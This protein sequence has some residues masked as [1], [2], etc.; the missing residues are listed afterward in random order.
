[1]KYL[2][3]A[4]LSIIAVLITGTAAAQRITWTPVTDGTMDWMPKKQAPT[5]YQ[6]I[7]PGVYGSDGSRAYVPSTV[8]PENGTVMQPNGNRGVFSG[9]SYME[10][11]P[12]GNLVRSCTRDGDRARCTNY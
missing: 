6:R 2:K 11:D 1:M 8:A 9:N 7:G 12:S 3:P 10:L 4:F 5:M